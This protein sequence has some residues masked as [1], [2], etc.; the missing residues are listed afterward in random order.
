M[1]QEF[2]EA[3]R[4]I[5]QA[6]NILLATHVDP[7]GDAVGS[8]LAMK[9][10]LEKT[11]KKATAFFL[12]KISDG[13]S[14]L[15]R[16]QEIT[17]KANLDGVDLIIGLD[18]GS[19][20]RLGL[21][22]KKLSAKNF[23]TIDHHSVGDHL[24]WQL[25]ENDYSSTSEIIYYLLSCWPVAIDRDIATC[26]L[27]GIYSDTG[28]FRHPNTSA[29]TLKIAGDLLLKG[30]PL[31]KIVRTAEGG[32]LP[33]GLDS[34]IEAF[35][36]IKIDLKSGLLFS[37]ISHKE[38][39]NF[40]HEFSGSAIASLFSTVPEI[41]FALLCA[42]KEPGQMECSLRSQSDRGVNVAKIAQL[43][44]GG[45]HRLAAGFQTTESPQAIVAKI[46]KMA[47]ENFSSAIKEV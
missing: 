2:F 27:V 20:D 16:F 38:L 4:V 29:Q 19:V 13:L 45:G 46:K 28:G 33:E 9:I 41:K 22:R 40:E 11:G 17:Y 3:K 15:P 25:V 21:D 6:K 14:W 32:G 34:W 39:I 7:D 36:N 23:L 44:G 24:G 18:Y 30:A 26:L 5:G 8:V 31:Q 12:S 37:L 1:N 10:G 43:F 42:E 47:L 35:K